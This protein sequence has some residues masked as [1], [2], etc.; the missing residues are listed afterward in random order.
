MSAKLR[1]PNINRI[2]INNISDSNTYRADY[3]LNQTPNHLK[4]LYIHHIFTSGAPV[5]YK[6]DIN[7]LS[8]TVAA[9]TKEVFIQCFEFSAADLQQLIRAACNAER[10]VFL[11]VFIALLICAQLWNDNQ[12]QHQLLR[13]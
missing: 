9:V 2:K 1:L 4:I 13:F 7:L 8:E 10:I 12:V 5:K 3:F 11:F 6:L